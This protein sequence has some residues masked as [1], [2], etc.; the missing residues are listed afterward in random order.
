MNEKERG[1]TKIRKENKNSRLHT[2]EGE[3]ETL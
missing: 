2:L 3:L 1:K